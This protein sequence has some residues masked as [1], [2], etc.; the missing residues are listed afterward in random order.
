M[1]MPWFRFYHEFVGDPVVQSLA[2]EDQRHFV[3]VLCLKASGFLD[4]PFPSKE[5]RHRMICHALGLDPVA[6]AEA[7]RRISEPGI[8]GQ[9]WQPTN[10][11]KRQFR[12][13]VS[14]DRV[15]EFRARQKEEESRKIQTTDYREKIVS[16]TF[17]QR[18]TEFKGAFP[19]RS[20]GQ[21]W[22]K[23]EKA[24]NARLTDGATWEEIIA[25]THRYASFCQL[26]G[27]VGTEYVMQAATFC[28]PDKRF[29]ED[30]RPPATKAD[31]RL[32]SNLDA[33]AEFLRRTDATA[34]S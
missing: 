9:D 11:D 33:A 7:L 5:V 30:W 10:W 8:V 1:G 12:S 19:R 34:G 21:P 32:G 14:T 15:K 22:P 13:D 27:K 23:A 29:L 3:M 17:L 16:E 2:F 24:I 26:T 18:F 6:G 4:K 28:G 20:G 31:V 25:G